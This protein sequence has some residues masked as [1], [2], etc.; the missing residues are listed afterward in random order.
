MTSQKSIQL[1]KKI[2]VKVMATGPNINLDQELYAI[3]WFDLKRPKLYN[4]YNQLAYKHVKAVGGAIQFKG[5]VIEKVKGPI[6]ND[7]K[8]LLI[9]RY[10][11]ASQFLSMIA[12]KMFLFK[13]VLRLK[14]VMHFTFGFAKRMSGGPA[15]LIVPK[16]YS[17]SSSYLFYHFQT[18]LSVSKYLYELEGLISNS[19]L[20]TYFM[21]SKAALIGRISGEQKLKTQTFLMDGLV[22]VESDNKSQLLQLLQNK[23]F[24]KLTSHNITNSIFFVKRV[25]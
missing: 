14:S 4:F 9:V 23:E 1:T 21:G 13:S 8:M 24:Q 22:L 18:K 19:G 25:I 5:T 11:S 17:G 7:R 16:A 3:N 10:P 20:S 6:E 12:N 2:T 15:P